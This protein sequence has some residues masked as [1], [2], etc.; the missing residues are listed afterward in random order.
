MSWLHVQESLLIPATPDAVY[1]VL[2]DYKVGH[3]AILPKSYFTELEVE[4]GGTGAGTKIRVHMNVMGRET[5]YHEIVTE[6]EPGRVLVETDAE[7]GVTT[8]FTVDPADNGEHARV[9]IATDMPARDGLFGW[10]E[11]NFTSF[12]MR[13][14][15]HEELEQLSG[16]LIEKNAA[17]A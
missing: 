11:R 12:I 13:R 6:P 8:T 17:N 2:A 15:Y 10:L 1:S 9:T 4:E 5:V 14:I 7:K 3:P 16:Y